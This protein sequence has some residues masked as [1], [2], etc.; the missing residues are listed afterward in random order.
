MPVN[1]VLGPV[2][3]DALGQTLVHEHVSGADWSLRA[4]FGTRFY[5]HDVILERATKHLTRAREAGVRT[6]VD[7]TPINLGRDV[8]L[9]REVAEHTGL[10]VVAS[11]GFYYTEHPYLQWRAEAEV[12]SW[13]DRECTD[14]IADTGIRPGIM[15]A[16]CAGAGLTPQLHNVFRAIGAVAASH[17]LPIFVHHEVEA[18][19]GQ[20]IVDL[21]DETGVAPGRL[22]VGHCGDSND[23]DYLQALLDR[24]VYLGMDRFGYCSVGNSLE[25]RVAT[26][27]AL[28]QRGY[29]AQLLLAHDLAV[30]FGVFGSWEDFVER[31]PLEDG[32][33]FTFIHTRVIPALV[34]AGLDQTTARAMLTDNPRALFG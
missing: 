12:A 13:L 10:T 7:G 15:K 4:A 29:A 11:T 34:A 14:G 18:A 5:D 24:G 26:I 19:N 32:V 23:L 1:T 27:V 31:D 16:A 6:I 9:L 33:D 3:A 28:A 20:A 17:D 8:A 25:N 21:F 30:Y 22:I 2:A